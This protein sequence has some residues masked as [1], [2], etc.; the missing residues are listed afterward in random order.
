L[1]KGDADVLTEVRRVVVRKQ[2]AR[3]CQ[4][5]GR[6]REDIADAQGTCT[7]E[8]RDRETE[9]AV[10]RQKRPSYWS[11]TSTSW[12]PARSRSEPSTTPIGHRALSG[13][14]RSASSTLLRV[15]LFTSEPTSSSHP[16]TENMSRVCIGETTRPLTSGGRRRSFEVVEGLPD[17][18]HGERTNVRP[19]WRS[20]HV[21]DNCRSFHI[22][23]SQQGRAQVVNWSERSTM[24]SRSAPK[25][26][27][28][29][30]W[31]GHNSTSFQRTLCCAHAP[32]RS[33]LDVRSPTS[34]PTSLLDDV[35]ST[36]TATNNPTNKKSHD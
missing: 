10:S 1:R 29:A 26:T 32:T 16:T 23:C 8:D 15:R 12:P 3:R 35:A 7:E 20:G 27:R 13:I 19:F 25:S 9:V 30:E 14:W 11:A 2:C 22:N 17:L 28:L 34:Q 4:S 33:L 21:C 6:Q 5:S 24:R 36:T 18:R 31:S